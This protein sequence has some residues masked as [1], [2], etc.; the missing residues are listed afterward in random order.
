MRSWPF[1]QCSWPFFFFTEKGLQCIGF[2]SSWQKLCKNYQIRFVNYQIRLGK[3]ERLR[4]SSSRGENIL[5]PDISCKT[6]SN[7]SHRTTFPS[8]Q[9][10]L[11]LT[12]QFTYIL[13]AGLQNNHHCFPTVQFY[14]FLHFLILNFQQ[15]EEGKISLEEFRRLV[16]TRLFLSHILHSTMVPGYYFLILCTIPG[17]QVPD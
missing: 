13:F 4:A 3:L 15:A 7:I 6:I 2:G 14:L 5:K 1:C 17:Y 11:F 9:T 10:L 8:T 12:E 16:D